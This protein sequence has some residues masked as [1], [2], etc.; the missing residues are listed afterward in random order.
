M[1]ELGEA[2]GLARGP[3]LQVVD[4]LAGVGVGLGLGLV[5]FL[6]DAWERLAPLYWFL[7]DSAGMAQQGPYPETNDPLLPFRGRGDR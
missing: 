7:T 4:D 1:A 2:L 6:W 3:A 5:D